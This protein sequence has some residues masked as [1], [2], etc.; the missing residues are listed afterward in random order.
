[1]NQRDSMR[2]VHVYYRSLGLLGS[3]LSS[4]ILIL[5]NGRA[6]KKWMILKKI[7]SVAKMASAVCKRETCVMA[8][9]ELCVGGVRALDGAVFLSHA[10]KLVLSSDCFLKRKEL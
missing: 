9:W 7:L 3:I 8:V 6:E 5:P 4:C 10:L 2:K 1:M